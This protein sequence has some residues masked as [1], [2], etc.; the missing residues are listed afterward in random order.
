MGR[1]LLYGV[2]LWAILS[3]CFKLI[4]DGDVI[5][6]SATQLRVVLPMIGVG[7]A[8]IVAL[9]TVISPAPGYDATRFGLGL[10]VPGLI[11]GAAALLVF[12]RLVARPSLEHGVVY[13]ILLLW[14][15]GLILSAVALLGGD[16]DD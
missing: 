14:T 15:Y 5:H 11:L 12:G 10:A 2:V 8:V 1:G 4:V 16:P 13:A 7:A 3:L 9:A 6:L